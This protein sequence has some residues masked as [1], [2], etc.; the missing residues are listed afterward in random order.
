MRNSDRYII[1]QILKSE[2]KILN[3]GTVKSLFGWFSIKLAK[4]RPILDCIQ[5]WWNKNQNIDLGPLIINSKKVRKILMLKML[6]RC[7]KWLNNHYRD[8]T[9]NGITEV[10]RFS[11]MVFFT[12][13]EMKMPK[14]LGTIVKM[15]KHYRAHFS[16]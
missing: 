2:G 5:K 1:R 9:E 12:V 4:F 15:K 3:G 16:R 6:H 11:V 8:V 14:D 7:L 10:F 13:T